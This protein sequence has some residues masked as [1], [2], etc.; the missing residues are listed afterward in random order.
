M[1]H[2]FQH[3][4]CEGEVIKT[5]L[6]TFKYKDAEQKLILLKSEKL[7][8][9]IRADG[10]FSIEEF[11][12]R[13]SLS[14]DEG[15]AIICLAEALLRISDNKTAGA[16]AE[17]KLSGKSWEKYLFKSSG[18][19]KTFLASF[20]L[21]LAGKYT[22]ILKSHNILTNLLNKLGQK[23]FIHTLKAAI[24]YLSGEFVFAEDMSDAIKKSKNFAGYKFS[25]DLL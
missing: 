22:D 4:D 8:N 16:L 10:K 2:I 19:L 17:D 23:P 1:N 24:K 3:N 5:L 7:I 12:H 15:V 20:G 6:P 14:S 18:S 21:Y 9:I 11:I 25:F 13:F